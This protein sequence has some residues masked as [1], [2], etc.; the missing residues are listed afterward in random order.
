MILAPITTMCGAEF[1]STIAIWA[2]YL[3]HP[4]KKAHILQYSSLTLAFWAFCKFALT[5]STILIS[6]FLS[7]TSNACQ[8]LFQ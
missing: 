7:F 2:W 3:F 5:L 4:L 1:S 8:P 6:H